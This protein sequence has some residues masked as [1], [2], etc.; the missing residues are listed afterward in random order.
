[1]AFDLSQSYAGSTI[2][3]ICQHNWCGSRSLTGTLHLLRGLAGL[4]RPPE[5]WLWFEAGELLAGGGQGEF[6]VVDPF[7]E[8]VVEQEFQAAGEVRQLLAGGEEGSSQGVDG[9]EVAFAEFLFE[10]RADDFP[11]EGFVGLGFW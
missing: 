7:D 3:C 2:N 1:M 4:A 8:F 9:D 5:E 10:V 11:G 6:V